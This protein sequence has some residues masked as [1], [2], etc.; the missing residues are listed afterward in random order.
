M[1]PAEKTMILNSLARE[2]TGNPTIN[3]GISLTNLFNQKVID[4]ISE[5][6][7]SRFWTIFTN[8]GTISAGQIG[9]II[10]IRRIKLIALI[11][12]MH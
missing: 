5:F 10:I 4:K 12:D 8:F 6:V 1:F 3:Q 2:I 11:F 9:L 7:W